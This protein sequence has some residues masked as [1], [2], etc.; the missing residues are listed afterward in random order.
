MSS[1]TM[2]NHLLPTSRM[3][4]ITHLSSH[5]SCC[6]YSLRGLNLDDRSISSETHSV[7]SRRKIHNP[8]IN[9]FQRRNVGFLGHTGPCPR[10][11][12]WHRQ[13]TCRL[14]CMSIVTSLADLL[15]WPN[16]THLAPLQDA[17]DR[18]RLYLSA[19]ILKLKSRRCRFNRSASR[20][21]HVSSGH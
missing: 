14:I 20:R 3:L 11:S 2:C 9:I 17:I 8:L 13:T 19:S 7:L 4:V 5:A 10:K 12:T 1:L 6:C 15:I 21:W 16:P 18:S